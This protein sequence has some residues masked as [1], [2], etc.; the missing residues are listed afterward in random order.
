MINC[1]CDGLSPGKNLFYNIKILDEGLF[2]KS[3]RKICLLY[4]Y[5]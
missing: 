5:P 2:K 4:G 3:V 1:V